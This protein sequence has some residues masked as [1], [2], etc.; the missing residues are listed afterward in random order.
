[1]IERRYFE[2]G[3]P[4]KA[5]AL[6]YRLDA[7]E[8]AAQVRAAEAELANRQ[9]V[10]A[11]A[12]LELDRSRALAAQGFVSARALDTAQT[13]LAVAEAGAR[14]AEA[15]LS[16]ARVNR[17]YT[18][19]RAPLDGVMGRALQVEGALVS[20]SGPALTTLAQG[21]Q[22]FDLTGTRIHGHL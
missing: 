11:E 22:H 3:A 5:G 2:E 6:L 20:P 7:A 1:M 21:L 19:I 14:T 12:K 13:A 4:V 10:L 17:G 9:A 8:P 15:N 18:E 16:N